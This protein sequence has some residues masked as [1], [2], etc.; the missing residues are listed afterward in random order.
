MKALN[1]TQEELAESLEITKGA[2]SHWLT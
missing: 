1:M 2:V